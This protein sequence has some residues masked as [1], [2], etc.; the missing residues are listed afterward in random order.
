MDAGQ[1]DR[2]KKHSSPTPVVIVFLGAQAGTLWR[3]LLN[4][5][6]PRP[7]F[8]LDYNLLKNSTQLFSTFVSARPRI[9]PTRA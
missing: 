8:A 7:P 6:I 9:R 3:I 1:A 4:H 2:K 5:L